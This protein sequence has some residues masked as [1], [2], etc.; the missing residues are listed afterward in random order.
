VHGSEPLIIQID[1]DK[2]IVYDMWGQ[3]E[4]VVVGYGYV[5]SYSGDEMM[6]R[7][8]KGN[9]TNT[10]PVNHSSPLGTHMV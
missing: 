10:G 5:M 6:R 2:Y 1:D 9:L 8:E 4:N 3:L 7:R